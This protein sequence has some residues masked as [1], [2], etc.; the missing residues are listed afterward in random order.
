MTPFHRLPK[1][2]QELI[3]EETHRRRERYLVRQERLR[4]IRDG[5]ITPAS[6][7]KPTPVVKTKD[8]SW[9]IGLEASIILNN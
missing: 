5:V 8:G 1:K 6:Q 3:S 2:H 4:R 7:M 9:A